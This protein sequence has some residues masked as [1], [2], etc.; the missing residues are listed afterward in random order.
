M[1]ELLYCASGNKEFPKEMEEETLE[2]F[3]H[4]NLPH[5]SPLEIVEV[6]NV[7]VNIRD[8]NDT[9]EPESDAVAEENETVS[10]EIASRDE[11]SD[12]DSSSP[13]NASRLG[14]G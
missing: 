2:E 12:P 3:K 8:S 4:P 9:D 10:E 14:C 5:K 6:I 7:A 11:D 13:R 1:L